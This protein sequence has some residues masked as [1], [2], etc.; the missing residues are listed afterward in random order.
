MNHSKISNE[1]LKMH[2]ECARTLDSAGA[3]EIDASV[4][5]VDPA[6]RTTAR[7]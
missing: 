7:T 6:G 2:H 5:P 4:T 1:Y 3:A